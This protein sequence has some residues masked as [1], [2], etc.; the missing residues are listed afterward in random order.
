[1]KFYLVTN[2]C[3]SLYMIGIKV[4]V[5][6]KSDSEILKES[7]EKDCFDF[8]TKS[9]SDLCSNCPDLKVLP[10]PKESLSL[11]RSEFSIL[12]KGRTKL[13]ELKVLLNKVFPTRYYAQL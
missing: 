7:L 11:P 3:T 10:T 4:T 5:F 8:K 9:S 1:M 2:D 12:M 6:S 13:K